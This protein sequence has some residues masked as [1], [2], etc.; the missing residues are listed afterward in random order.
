MSISVK[1]F[2]RG[3]DKRCLP[4]H[5]ESFNRI[6]KEQDKWLKTYYKQYSVY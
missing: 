2:G 3:E 1:G 5:P 4:F 6:N